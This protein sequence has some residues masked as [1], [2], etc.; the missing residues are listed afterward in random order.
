[1]IKRLSDKLAQSPM[2]GDGEIGTK[3]KGG[4]TV[5]EHGDFTRESQ[6]VFVRMPGTTADCHK[7]RSSRAAAWRSHIVIERTSRPSFAAGPRWRLK[8]LQVGG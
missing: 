1:M 3:G 6:G 2:K 5:R 8:K 7:L 4:P